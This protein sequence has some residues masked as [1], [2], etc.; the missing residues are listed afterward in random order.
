MCI[1]AIANYAEHL[2]MGL[3]AICILSSLKCLSMLFVHFLFRLFFLLLSFESS[4][5]IMR[6]SILPDEQ[7]M[8]ILRPSNS[9]GFY[10][11]KVFVMKSNLSNFLFMDHAF[12]VTFRTSEQPQI[13]NIFSMFSLKVLYFYFTFYMMINFELIF[14]KM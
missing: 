6:T 5:Y 8:N 11:P 3:L 2:S 13:L 14:Y 12:C 4:Q 1:S 7:L 9:T 10:I